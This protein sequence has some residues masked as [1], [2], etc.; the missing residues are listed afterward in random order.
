MGTLA[1]FASQPVSLPASTAWYLSDLG[2]FRGKQELDLAPVSPDPSYSQCNAASWTVDWR[3][4]A[5]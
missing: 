4:S 2:E 5:A 3:A 1:Q